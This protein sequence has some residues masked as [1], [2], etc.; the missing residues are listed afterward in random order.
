MF[1]S[2]PYFLIAESWIC[3]S[4][5]KILRLCYFR[6]VIRIIKEWEIEKKLT[7]VQ[8]MS[9]N[10]DV[11]KKYTNNKIWRQHISKFNKFTL[12][13]GILM[14]TFDLLR[15]SSSENILYGNIYLGSA[16]S[17]YTRIFNIFTKIVR[18]FTS[19]TKKKMDNFFYETFL[20]FQQK[21][22][23]YIIKIVHSLVKKI[24]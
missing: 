6:K 3:L 12:L 8:I 14:K 22:H 4:I 21:I 7:V 10:I 2:D 1:H 15:A 20:H 16:Y 24:M 5:T 18:P 19:T 17:I 9:W 23:I 13:N 11:K